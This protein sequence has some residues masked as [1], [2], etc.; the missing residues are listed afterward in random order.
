VPEKSTD[1]DPFHPHTKED[2]IP[3]GTIVKLEIGIWPCGLAFDKGEGLRLC[4]AGHTLVL[5]E[6]PG[7]KER[8]DNVGTHVVHTGGEY[9]SYLQVPKI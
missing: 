4:I 2:K 3:P 1:F 5:P 6:Y 7:L 9:A 8:Q